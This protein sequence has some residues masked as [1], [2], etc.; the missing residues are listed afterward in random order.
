VL[1]IDPKKNGSV[2]LWVFL[3]QCYQ[4]VLNGLLTLALLLVYETPLLSG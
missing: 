4:V 2:E 3:V 1:A